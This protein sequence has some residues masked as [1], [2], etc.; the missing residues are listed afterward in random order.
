M[1]KTCC[2]ILGLSVP[3]RQTASLTAD[4]FAGWSKETFLLFQ[5]QQLTIKTGQGMYTATFS[6]SVRA[7]IKIACGWIY[8]PLR[9][10]WLAGTRPIPTTQSKKE[11]SGLYVAKSDR[12]RR[13]AHVSS[14]TASCCDLSAKGLP[15]RENSASREMCL[16]LSVCLSGCRATGERKWSK[17]GSKDQLIFLRR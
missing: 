11:Q 14:A 10:R 6:I 2:R 1:T 4:Q 15:S 13:S 12:R 8:C 9:G 17:C 3:L 7:I 16:C 5:P